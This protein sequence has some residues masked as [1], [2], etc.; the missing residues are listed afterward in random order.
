M[1]SMVVTRPLVDIVISA[2]IY[3]HFTEDYYKHPA[4]TNGTTSPPPFQLII[5]KLFDP[6]LV[7]GWLNRRTT[8]PSPSTIAE[9]Q[10]QAVYLTERWNSQLEN[11]LGTWVTADEDSA[12]NE[13]ETNAEDTELRQILPRKDVFYYDLPHYI[14]GLMVE[15]QLE[16]AGDGAFSI[17]IRQDLIIHSKQRVEGIIC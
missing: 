2:G 16:D 8:A 17:F 3:T 6:S 15:H 10:K 4:S 1:N 5:P 11:T 12:P 13:S 7:P 14:L 9:Q